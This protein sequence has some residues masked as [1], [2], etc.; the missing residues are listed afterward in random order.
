MVGLL[1]G[2][3]QRVVALGPL[4]LLHPVDDAAPVARSSIVE[5][6]EALRLDH[7]R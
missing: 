6:P 7:G 2:I 5:S 4:R 3:L 1:D